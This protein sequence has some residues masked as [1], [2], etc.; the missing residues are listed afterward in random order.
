MSDLRLGA[1]PGIVGLDITLRESQ[2]GTKA[3]ISEKV[4][5]GLG[6]SHLETAHAVH[7]YRACLWFPELIERTGWNGFN[8]E[9]Q[10]LDKAQRK[11]T[12]LTEAYIK[13]EDRAQKLE[14][15]RVV[16]EKASQALLQ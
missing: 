5:I 3:A 7:N 10:I 2:A 4:G 13:P 6:T 12:A 1:G 11:V 16:V 8:N 14:A 9:R 15:M